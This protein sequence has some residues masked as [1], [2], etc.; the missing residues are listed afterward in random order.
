MA[1]HSTLTLWIDV[2]QTR[3]FDENTV[4]DYYLDVSDSLFLGYFPDGYSFLLWGL[5]DEVQ[6]AD[7][8]RFIEYPVEVEVSG[9]TLLMLDDSQGEPV[10]TV[11][12]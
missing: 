6:A 1:N 10:L 3:E 9:K 11:L 8:S 4:Q 7:T 2:S 5:V 12:H